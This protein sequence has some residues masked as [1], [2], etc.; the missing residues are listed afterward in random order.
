MLFFYTWRDTGG[1][2]QGGTEQSDR[3][4]SKRSEQQP[5]SNDSN[6]VEEWF[7]NKTGS[8]VTKHEMRHD[9][10]FSLPAYHLSRLAS[11]WKFDS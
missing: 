2:G 4:K 11:K 9:S 7:L 8:D 3:W 6:T 1:N 10:L 5:Y